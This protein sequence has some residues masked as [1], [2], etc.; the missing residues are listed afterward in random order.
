VA[1]MVSK[2]WTISG[3][4]CTSS[5]SQLIILDLPP[6]SHAAKEHILRAF[7]ATHIEINC[8]NN[9]SLDPLQ[10]SFRMEEGYLEA[11]SFHHPLPDHMATNCNC[12]KCAT[13]RCPCRQQILPCSAFCKCQSNEHLPCKNPNKLIYEQQM[14]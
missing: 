12:I 3:T 7:Y 14:N 10:Y 2:H 5:G 9:V 1:T 11:E 6:T 4:T 13:S 8:L